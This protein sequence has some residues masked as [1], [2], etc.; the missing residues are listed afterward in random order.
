MKIKF[1]KIVIA[2]IVQKKAKELYFHCGP[3]CKMKKENFSE[4]KCY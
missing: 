2:E 4:G 1:L 3:L